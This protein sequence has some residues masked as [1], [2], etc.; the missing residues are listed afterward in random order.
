[1]NDVKLYVMNTG[2]LAFSFSDYVVDILRII[3]L[4]V[5]IVYTIK[6][7]LSIHGKKNK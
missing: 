5:T 7:T 3:L 2:A 4:L 1:M 6:K